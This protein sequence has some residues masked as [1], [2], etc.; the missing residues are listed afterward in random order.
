MRALWNEWK[1]T[2]G[3]VSYAVWL[4][5]RVAALESKVAKLSTC[6]QQTKVTTKPKCETCWNVAY[7]ES[8][9]RVSKG[10][11]DDWR[12]PIVVV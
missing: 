5:N 7:C 11:C 9:L 6:K 12:E 8:E 4:E 3:D 2:D 10:F 1:Q